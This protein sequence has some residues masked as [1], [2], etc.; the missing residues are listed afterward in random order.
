M[1]PKL[2]AHQQQERHW[3][4]VVVAK[5]WLIFHGATRS[6]IRQF[7]DL[8]KASGAEVIFG[9]TEQST[10]WRNPMGKSGRSNRKG[11]PNKRTKRLMKVEEKRRRNASRRKSV[12]GYLSK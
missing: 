7:R 9:G 10:R 11:R 8:R 12:R 2:T 1:K 5:R 4:D 3:R 6:A